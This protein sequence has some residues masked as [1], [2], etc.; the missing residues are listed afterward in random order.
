[1]TAP[2][3][4]SSVS[5]LASDSTISTPSVVPATT[6]SSVARL[7]LLERRVEHVLA[8]DVA[9]ARGGDRAQE[10]DA[11][12]GQRGR[13]GRPWRRC[14]DRSP[15]RAPARCDD[16]RLVAIAF[17][18]QRADRAVDQA[19]G[20]D[21]LLARTAFALEEAAGDLAGGEGLLLVVDGQ[22]EEI[23]AGLRLLRERRRWPA[24]WCR[25]RWPAPRRRPGGRSCRF[26]GSACGRAQS[27]SLRNTLNISV[28][29]IFLSYTAACP[30]LAT[31]ARRRPCAGR[32][33]PG[34]CISPLPSRLLRSRVSRPNSR[35]PDDAT[36]KG[37][38]IKAGP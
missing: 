28:I 1:M 19:R 29:S 27:I 10:R 23:E 34:L 14:R 18:E 35:G 37:P 7:D 9:D 31:T 26:R 13:R 12:D 32:T 3:M 2:S 15:G 38:A 25:R 8:V 21:L 24:P 6:R 20:Q 33:G 30:R 16:L 17:E 11:G 22:R 4:T 5:S 36:R